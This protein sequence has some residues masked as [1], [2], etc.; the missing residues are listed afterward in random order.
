MSVPS[1]LDKSLLSVHGLVQVTTL[2]QDME[3]E[4]MV[5]ALAEIMPIMRQTPLLSHF[6][7]LK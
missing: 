6:G 5:T 2:L 3:P 4:D 1:Y 7:E